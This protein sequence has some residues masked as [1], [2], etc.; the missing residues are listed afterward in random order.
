MFFH[1]TIDDC[2]ISI[3]RHK[4]TVNTLRK[5]NMKLK[6]DNRVVKKTL[7]VLDCKVLVLLLYFGQSSKILKCLANSTF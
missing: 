2:K 4:N 1:K 6:E 3:E 5:E 7:I